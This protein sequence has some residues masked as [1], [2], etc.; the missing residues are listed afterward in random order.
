MPQRDFKRIESRRVLSRGRC[1]VV[2]GSTAKG[3][4]EKEIKQMSFDRC[5]HYMKARIKYLARRIFDLRSEIWRLA[6]DLAWANSEIERLRKLV[7]NADKQ[8]I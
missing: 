3:E 5:P 6:K 8:S 7:K 2:I 1:K 4:L